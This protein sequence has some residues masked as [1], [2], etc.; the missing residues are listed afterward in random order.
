[1]L[2]HHAQAEHAPKVG[3]GQGAMGSMNENLGNIIA[4]SSSMLF[5]R[6]YA[7]GVRVGRPALFNYVVA[8]VAFLNL[9]ITTVEI[10]DE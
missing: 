10:R 3:I 1:M 8:V 9:A 7:F 5:A 4:M 6:I 2:I